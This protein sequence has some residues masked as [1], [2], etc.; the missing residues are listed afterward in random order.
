MSS[1]SY[2]S[3]GG[4]WPAPQPAHRPVPR[5]LLP[6]VLLIVAGALAIGSAF[7]TVAVSANRL[8]DDS[9]SFAGDAKVNIT[10]TTAWST[11]FSV[12]GGHTG[13]PFDG[14][15]LVLAGAVALVV[16]VLLLAGRGRWAWT[17]PAAAL[18][19]GLLAGVVLMALLRF[20]ELTSWDFRDEAQSVDTTAGPAIWL[21]MP[22]ILLAIVAAA[23]AMSRST[24][25]PNVAMPYYA[26]YPQQQQPPGP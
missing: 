1:A 26:P 24:P 13:Q 19:S 15:G 8:L 18:A 14:W 23:L 7:L 25:R 20:I 2:Q 6:A 16:A 4:Q 5:G 21:Q 22:A 9:S 10:T 12:P 11:T 17:R 3:P